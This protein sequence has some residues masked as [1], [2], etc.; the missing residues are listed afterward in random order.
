MIIHEF[1]AEERLI[2][3]RKNYS[4][5]NEIKESLAEY[6]DKY[7]ILSSEINIE[8]DSLLQCCDFFERTLLI[9]CYT[10]SEQLVKNFVYEILEKDRHENIFLNRF[11]ENKIPKNKFSPNV[12]YSSIGKLVSEELCQKYK[13]SLKSTS[14]CFRVYDEMV[15]S[16]HTY[17]HSGIYAFDFNNFEIVIQVLEFLY[18]ELKMPLE[19]DME[20]R[21]K[22]QN[23]I[24]Q[25]ET[26]T[27]SICK[28]VESK[29]IDSLNFRAYG[30]RLN[31]LKTCCSSF[32]SKYYESLKH[33]KLLS[34]I[35]E[36]VK[37]LSNS[38]L[39]SK[40]EFV[41]KVVELNCLIS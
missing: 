30:T 7:R 8:Q 28:I 17:A 35:L 15:K 31:T 6:R 1:E 19:D 9:N 18:S 10:F 32:T 33:V 20:Y 38:D 34:P 2:D 27:K 39:R 22:Y 4:Q 26:S 37:D 23:L 3:I 29:N 36:K 24:S 12:S 5:V 41:R 21:E 16:R 13:F 25:I 40:K 14:S 11:I